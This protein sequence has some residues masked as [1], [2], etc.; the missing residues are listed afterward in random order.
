MRIKVISSLLAIFM[1]F[2][3]VASAHPGRT[4]S[5]GGHTCRTNCAKWGLKQG[6]YHYH[7]GGSSSSS[8]SSSS[9][10][11]SSGSTKKSNKSSTATQKKATPKPEY[12]KSA[13][14]VKVN[15]SKVIFTESPII[16][17]NTN[18]VPL[19]EMAKAMKAKTS[20]DSKTQTITVTKDKYKLI[21]TL[22]SKKVKVNGKE[23]TLQA[24]PKEI[25]GTTYIPLRVLVEG[26]GASLTSSGNTLTVKVKE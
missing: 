20:W 3:T 6:E 26:L 8:K 2:A 11:S 25:K 16:M 7:N 24:A 10:S 23:V 13:V 22:S 14:Q 19:R 1:I 21:F 5:S 4:D 9:S 18:L 12:I 15:G 17:N